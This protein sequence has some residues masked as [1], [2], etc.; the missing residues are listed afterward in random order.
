M[1]VQDLPLSNR[2]SAVWYHG[3][4]ALYEVYR[5]GIEGRPGPSHALIHCAGASRLLLKFFCQAAGRRLQFLAIL[6]YAE[7]VSPAAV[8]CFRGVASGDV[9]R[10][11][12]NCSKR[13]CPT[14]HLAYHLDHSGAVSSR[15]WILVSI[16]SVWYRSPVTSTLARTPSDEPSLPGFNLFFLMICLSP[17]QCFRH[18]A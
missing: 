5:E 4:D 1:H 16:A 2:V 8:G 10:H 12:G 17:L 11:A 15:R 9:L 3:C 6:P 7:T 13:R 14:G 18:Y